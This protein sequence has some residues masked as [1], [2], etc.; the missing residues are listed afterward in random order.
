LRTAL[1]TQ[2]SPPNQVLIGLSLFLT[3]FV[4]SPTIDQAYKEGL[5]P[6]IQEKMNE[7]EALEH[8]YK[9]FQHFM[10]KNVR[11]KDLELFMNL[12]KVT[13]TDK[14]E[15]IPFRVLVPAFMSSELRRSF[16][17]GFLLYVPFFVIDI[18]VSCVLMSM[19]MMMLPPVMI[20]LP[21][22]L[23]FFVIV[24]GWHL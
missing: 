21:F 17:M 4:M 16:E 23:L 10:I 19:G 13:K 8:I 24:D 3:L 22:K 14:Y 20:A 2:Q 5:E 18:V 1:G 15:E 11:T 9:P 6:L 12:A 7:K